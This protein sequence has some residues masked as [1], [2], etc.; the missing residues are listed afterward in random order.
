M[1]NRLLKLEGSSNFRDLGGYESSNGMKLKKG[2]IY[3]S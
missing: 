1:N 3:R 2:L